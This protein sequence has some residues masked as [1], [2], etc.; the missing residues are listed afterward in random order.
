[1][2]IDIDIVSE[3]QKA[4]LERVHVGKSSFSATGSKE[5]SRE[6]GLKVESVYRDEQSR[7]IVA[8]AESRDKKAFKQLFNMKPKASRPKSRE[9][10][11]LARGFKAR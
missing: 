1:M 9:I 3:R 5:R 7:W 8:V 11:M 10:Y 4:G 6:V 2:S